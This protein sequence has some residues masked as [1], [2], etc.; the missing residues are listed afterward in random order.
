MGALYATMALSK[1]ETVNALAKKMGLPPVRRDLI[2]IRPTDAVSAVM[3]DSA[4]IARAWQDPLPEETDRLF[5]NAIDD[6]VSGRL[7]INQALT[8]VQS[9]IGKV[10]QSYQNNN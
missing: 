7:N 9:G 2:A 6:I 3:Y 8:V 1:A 4:L 10:L 5:G